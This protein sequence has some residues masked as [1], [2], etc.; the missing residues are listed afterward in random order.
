MARYGISSPKVFGVSMATM[1]PLVKT[2]GRDHA[3]ALKLWRTGWLEARILASL[4]DNATLVTGSQMEEWARDFD[5]WAVCDSVCLHLFSYAPPRWSKATAWPRR[6]AEFVR[7]AGCALIASLAVHDK[8]ATQRQFET[9]LPLLE[10]I[11][12]DERPMVTKGVS[13]ALR[14]VGKRDGALHGV[15]VPIAERLRTHSSASA[16]W[17]GR[18][19]VKDLHSDAVRARLA[20]RAKSR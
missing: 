8:A 14:Q 13:W 5:N 9:C 6:Q 1:R 18:D 2:L 19:V 16:R 15:V 11:A 3:L 12:D 17:I 7:R 20:R 10:A 4:I